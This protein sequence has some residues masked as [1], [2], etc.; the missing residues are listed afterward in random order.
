MNIGELE[1]LNEYIGKPVTEDVLIGRN[2]MH[3]VDGAEVPAPWTYEIRDFELS[4][5]EEDDYEDIDNDDSEDIDEG[6][7]ED[8]EDDEDELDDEE[9]ETEEAMLCRL[10]GSDIWVKHT[11]VDLMECEEYGI[12]FLSCIL[13]VRLADGKTIEKINVIVKAG[14][15]F[16]SFFIIPGMGL[17]YEYINPGELPPAAEKELDMLIAGRALKPGMTFT[18]KKVPEEI[19]G[20]ISCPSAFRLAYYSLMYEPDEN[21][22]FSDMVY[23]T[24][25]SNGSVYGNLFTRPVSLRDREDEAKDCLLFILDMC[26]PE[27]YDRMQATEE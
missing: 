24:Y 11:A 7:V 18:G 6:E 25:E 20:T 12:P 5:D 22:S 15:Q 26:T 14:R 17:R 2:Y 13:V 3:L 23:E 16:S 1:E 27:E 9:N 10:F 21:G 19:D 8:E 4:V